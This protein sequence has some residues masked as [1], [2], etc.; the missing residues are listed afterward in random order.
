MFYNLCSTVSLKDQFLLQGYRKRH[1]MQ[2]NAWLKLVL[3]NN[4]HQIRIH[5]LGNIYVICDFREKRL[6]D[7]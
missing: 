6:T 1:A 3:F 4:V 5:D 2:L 7:L